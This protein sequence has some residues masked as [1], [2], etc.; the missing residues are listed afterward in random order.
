MSKGQAAPDGEMRHS[1]ASAF[2]IRHQ[3]KTHAEVEG[4]FT[5]RCGA[6]APRD[7]RPCMYGFAHGGHHEWEPAGP[8][9]TQ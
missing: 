3:L 5:R 7:K 4:G 1:S 8:V 6:R 9:V 2:E